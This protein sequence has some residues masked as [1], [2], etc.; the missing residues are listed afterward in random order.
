MKVYSELTSYFGERSC[1]YLETKYLVYRDMRDT[2]PLGP[3]IPYTF[4]MVYSE[5]GFFTN[6]YLFLD[7]YVCV[8]IEV[9]LND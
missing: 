7:S 3:R 5:P 2:E 8:K 4:A 6:Y 9:N 1:K